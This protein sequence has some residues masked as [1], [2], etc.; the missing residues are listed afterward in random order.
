MGGNTNEG[1]ASSVVSVVN[2]LDTLPP[3][4]IATTSNPYSVAGLSPVIV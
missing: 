1:G 4:F 2:P 3:S